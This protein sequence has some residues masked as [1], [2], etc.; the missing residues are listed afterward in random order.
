MYAD[1]RG[2][3]M[4]EH[5]MGGLSLSDKEHKEMMSG[6]KTTTWASIASQPAKTQSLMKKKAGMPPPPIM[7]SKLR[8]IHVYFGFASFLY[9][10]LYFELGNWDTKNGTVAKAPIAAPVQA[11]RPP[12]WERMERPPNMPPPSGP[13]ALPHPSSSV[14]TGPVGPLMGNNAPG[15]GGF[16]QHH[17]QMGYMPP[18]SQS[19]PPPPMNRDNRESQSHSHGISQ[20]NN[21]ANHASSGSNSRSSVEPKPTS[22]AIQP[23]YPGKN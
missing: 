19:H 4:M 11:P 10:I 2:M 14:P 13:S 15:R 3:K 9:F 18:L 1:E 20:S 21:H 6:K 17:Q 16:Q 12:A 7:L 22:Q 5:G 23:Q 8:N